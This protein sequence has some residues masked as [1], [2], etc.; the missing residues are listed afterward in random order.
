MGIATSGMGIGTFV[1][2]PFLTWVEEEI[3]WRGA[4]IILSG[5]ILNIVVFGALVRPMD[6]CQTHESNRE[7]THRKESPDGSESCYSSSS[8]A[9]S[10]T[11]LFCNPLSEP[12]SEI[13]GRENNEHSGSVTQDETSSFWNINQHSNI[14]K[15][16]DVGMESSEK[17]HNE[18][19]VLSTESC[20]S[21]TS[22][23]SNETTRSKSRKVNQ[24]PLN[25]KEEADMYSFMPSD[26]LR[27]MFFFSKN[28][29]S[30]STGGDI[31]RNP[32][33][34]T[35][36]KSFNSAKFENAQQ[37]KETKYDVS[38]NKSAAVTEIEATSS[39]V[40]FTEDK[41]ISSPGAKGD[42]YLNTFKNLM[43]NPYYVA[44]AVS[45]F[46]TCLT[47][48]MPPVYIADRAIENGVS[49]TNAAL[50]L[51]MYGAGNLFGR[52]GFGVLADH[53]LDSLVLNSF[54]LIMCGVST[55]LSPLCGGNAVLH[56]AYGFTF[57]TFIVGLTKKNCRVGNSCNCSSRVVIIVVVV[58]V[59][60]VVVVAVVVVVE[61]VVVVIVVVVVAAAAEEE[62]AE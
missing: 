15:D 25:L 47:Y 43:K 23:N 38:E 39:N 4:M 52:F 30:L 28:R 55:C 42:P 49:K 37:C 53:V 6:S 56:G 19:N 8:F 27:K 12:M 7:H 41:K 14:M 18:M 20:E 2:P 3:H 13:C 29:Y 33:V 22:Y 60:I 10:P 48:L 36:G 40:S 50:A 51:S 61:V 54:C 21:I 5:L 59:I 31:D 26:K 35:T 44:V 1:Y 17:Y 9:E 32:T 16:Q 57:G 11:S 62:E 46:L 58:A 45:N 34:Y 24:S